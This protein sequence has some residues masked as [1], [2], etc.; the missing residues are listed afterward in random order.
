MGNG[1]SKGLIPSFSLW[2][3]VKTPED[4]RYELTLPSNKS[5]WVG[6]SPKIEIAS[7]IWIK[8]CTLAG[9]VG[10][11]VEVWLNDFG[12][13]LGDLVAISTNSNLD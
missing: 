2:D 4:C 12:S 7:N 8:V 10:E 6:F 11:S 13:E 5:V 9:S 3:L 1:N